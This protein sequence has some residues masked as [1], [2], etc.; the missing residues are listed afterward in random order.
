[1]VMFGCSPKMANKLTKA[2]FVIMKDLSKK[3]P[4]IVDLDKAKE[5]V[6]RERETNLKKNNFWLR[7]LESA[8]QNG[9]DINK[10]MNFSVSGSKTT[11]T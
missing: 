2:V 1:M 6:I 7:K 10:T 3:G 11:L 8:Y 4:S 5:A 9:D